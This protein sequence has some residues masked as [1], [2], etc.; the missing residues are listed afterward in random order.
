MKNILLG[1]LADRYVDFISTRALIRSEL[2]ISDT[3]LYLIVGAPV[4]ILLLILIGV[5][6]KLL[7]KD[8]K[9][10]LGALF[11][12]LGVLAVLVI[13]G[14]FWDPDKWSVVVQLV[15]LGSLVLY[16]LKSNPKRFIKILLITLACIAGIV[17]I[18]F[19]FGPAIA[20]AVAFNGVMTLLTL[21]SLG[22][23]R[24][25]IRLE[26]EGLRTEGRFVRWETYGRNSAAI[27]AYTTEDGVYHEEAACEFAAASRK[28]K[29]QTFTLLYY[30]EEP[31]IIYIHKYSLI[32]CITGFCIFSAL[33]LGALGFSI[34]LLIQFR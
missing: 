15:I 24:E 18:G 27:F 23:L 21:S 11:A 2:L 7:I 12:V 8:P 3:V 31:S 33:S 32:G 10:S 17:V 30:K 13:P 25:C 14:L 9:G 22:S 4:M 19:A 5:F 16:A 20:A 28:L 29:K 26:K 6:I 1:T 34:Y